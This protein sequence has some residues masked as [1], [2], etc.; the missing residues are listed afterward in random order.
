M[1]KVSKQE[2]QALESR[3]RGNFIQSLLGPKTTFL[4][5]S[6]GVNGVPNLAIFNNLIHISANLPLYGIQFRPEEGVGRDTIRNIRETKYFTLNSV[7][8]NM[9]VKAHQTSA[10]YPDT[11]SEFDAVGLTVLDSNFGVPFVDESPVHIVLKYNQ[12]LTIEGSAVTILLGE[13]VEVQ[14]AV[15]PEID[16]FVAADKMG[17]VASIGL[18]SYYNLTSIG[19]LEYAKPNEP[20]SW[21]S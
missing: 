16:G 8:E 5:G 15:E 2:I 10:K 19:R 4:L 9:V 12:T 6:K 18:D 3:F 13:I 14:V 11:V 17:N 1:F 7:T 21:K 20:S